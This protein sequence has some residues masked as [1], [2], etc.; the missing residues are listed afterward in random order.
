MSVMEPVALRLQLQ[1][2]NPSTAP[3]NPAEKE[4]QHDH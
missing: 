1:W 2:N 3:N 4:T